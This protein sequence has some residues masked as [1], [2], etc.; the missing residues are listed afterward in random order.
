MAR[1]F[2]DL[3]EAAKMLG[4]TPDT[5]AEMRE[6]QRFTAIATAGVGSSSPRTSRRL[7]AERKPPTREGEFAE[8]DEDPDSILLSEVELGQSDESTSSTIIGG[9]ASRTT[10]PKAIFNWPGPNT[11]A[12]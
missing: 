9:R 1:K 3:D 2:I 12:T 6:R 11:T 4:V 5:L 7:V 10:R 8:L